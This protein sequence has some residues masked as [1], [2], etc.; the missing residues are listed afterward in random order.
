MATERSVLAVIRAARPSFRNCHD[1]I[2][3]LLHAA[4]LSAGFS[5]TSVG[6]AA[7]SLS[8][9]PPF[10]GNEDKEIDGW[11]EMK[12]SYAFCYERS[13]NGRSQSI[14]VKALVVG[15]LLVVDA[16]PYEKSAKSEICNL[17]I[18]VK[19]FCKEG[20]GIQ[21]LAEH[22]KNLPALLE[23]I[24][25]ALLSRVEKAGKPSS[26]GKTNAGQ[27]DEGTCQKTPGNGTQPYPSC[28][29][30]DHPGYATPPIPS[31][32]G[33]DLLPGPGAGIFPHRSGLSSG[34]GMLLGPND[35]RWRI[36]PGVPDPHSPDIG[37]G[38]R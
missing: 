14:I 12:D 34:G 1:K 31:I 15:D 35:P 2:A 5:L 18:N 30:Q 19:E 9:P 16:V 6:S 37:I 38:F 26:D 3:F 17:D 21:N 36:G 8:A 27:T 33:D 29:Q 28:G 11:N 24:N 10:S 4:F 7:A 22:Y 13:D 23:K 25:S 20:A 32:G